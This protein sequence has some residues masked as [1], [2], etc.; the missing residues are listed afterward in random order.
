MGGTTETAD[1]LNSIT[2]ETEA[3][4]NST[5]RNTSLRNSRSKLPSFPGLGKKT[6]D[7]EKDN[8]EKMI[9]MKNMSSS[10][11]SIKKPQPSPKDMNKTHSRTSLHATSNGDS[12]DFP[13]PMLQKKI[14][15]D[16][17]VDGNNSLIAEEK[18]SLVSDSLQN[19]TDN[20]DTH[21]QMTAD[22]LDLENSTVRLT[23]MQVSSV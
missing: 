18:V 23:S 5:Q 14:T 8:K 11:D 10:G 13:S 1:A 15:N 9:S 20:S 21:S 6:K 12:V 17:K 3:E 4:I 22:S 7:K 16:I 19:S 2:E